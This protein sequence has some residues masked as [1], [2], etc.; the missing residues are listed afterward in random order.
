VLIER[1][2]I[3]ERIPHKGR[4]CLLDGVLA[5]DA[6]SIRCMATSHR[7]PDNPLRHRDR[8]AALCGIEYAAQ[9]MALHGALCGA[10]AT[11]RAGYLAG[12]RDCVC[13]IARLDL[14]E[15]DLLIEARRIFDDGRHSLYEFALHCNELELLSGRAAVVLDAG[16][17]EGALN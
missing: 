3:A 10:V 14:L 5:W 4:M 11:P 6:G 7:D 8:L 15:A 9:A 12:V 2:A 13:R 16:P 1:A 17:L